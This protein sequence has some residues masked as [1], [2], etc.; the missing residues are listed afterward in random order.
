MSIKTDIVGV[1]GNAGTGSSS[2]VNSSIL[3]CKMGEIPDQAVVSS[4]RDNMQRIGSTTGSK[5]G[6]GPWLFTL[7]HLPGCPL[8]KEGI[9]SL[10]L[11]H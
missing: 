10:W 3:I 4:K 6:S 2:C 8:A 11:F 1:A 9:R 5:T 7:A